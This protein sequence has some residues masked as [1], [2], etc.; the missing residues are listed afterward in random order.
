MYGSETFATEVSSTSIK[1][2]SMMEIAISHGF[3]A[4]FHSLGSDAAASTL[5]LTPSD[6]GGS[7]APP[8]QLHWPQEVSRYLRSRVSTRRHHP[9][10]QLERPTSPGRAL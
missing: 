10:S 2:A 3:T 7:T 5:M 6:P 4:G 1:V 8:Q 9:R